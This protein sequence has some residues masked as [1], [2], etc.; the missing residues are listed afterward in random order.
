M[1]SSGVQII[2]ILPPISHTLLLFSARFG[3]L[4]SACSSRLADSNPVYRSYGYMC[5]VAKNLR[6]K[7]PRS[8]DGWRQRIGFISD[9]Q[10][11]QPADDREP[12]LNFRRIADRD[13]VD[14]D[15][16]DR[17]LKLATS[18]RP[19]VLCGLLVPSDDH[20]AAWTSNQIADECGLQVHRFHAHP[21]RK[22]RTPAGSPS[23]RFSHLL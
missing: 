20:V 11:R 16:G 22:R 2:G 12:L 1:S 6:R 8:H 21:L 23:G 5:S 18:I 14:D 7:D 10:I 19:P 3:R 13:L 9:C 17:A 15:L 4:P